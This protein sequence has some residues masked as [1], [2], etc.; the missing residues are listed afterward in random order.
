MH[1]IKGF[2]DIIRGNFRKIILLNSNF[3]TV[4]GKK[5]HIFARIVS[6]YFSSF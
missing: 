5:N 4:G 6:I 1:E 3:G 2:G